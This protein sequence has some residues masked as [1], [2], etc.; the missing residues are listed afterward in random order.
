MAMRIISCILRLVE[1][2]NSPRSMW[3]QGPGGA[4]KMKFILNFFKETEICFKLNFPGDL[5]KF[6]KKCQ[7]FCEEEIQSNVV[8]ITKN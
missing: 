1:G 5:T 7:N 3:L 4:K 8:V 6:F 2:G